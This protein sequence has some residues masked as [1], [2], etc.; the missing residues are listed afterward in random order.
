MPKTIE[1]KAGQQI[2][3]PYDK[4]SPVIIVGTTTNYSK[5]GSNIDKNGKFTNERVAFNLEGWKIWEKSCGRDWRRNYMW[6]NQLGACI[7]SDYPG[8][9]AEMEAKAKAY[10]D[11]VMVDDDDIVI[12]EGFKFRV[13]CIKRQVSDPVHF[14]LID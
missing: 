4:Y 14:H 8:K 10:E 12:C 3:T 13:V 9:A 1:L 11:A 7:T 2:K 5:D 6:A